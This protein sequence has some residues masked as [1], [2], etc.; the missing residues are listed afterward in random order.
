VKN[1][2]KLMGKIR[3]AEEEI[4][5]APPKKAAKLAS[6]IVLWKNTIFDN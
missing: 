5:F 4:A 3:K 6:K 1:Q 2:K